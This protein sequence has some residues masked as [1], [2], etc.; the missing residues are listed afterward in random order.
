VRFGAKAR[1]PENDGRAPRVGAVLP[2]DFETE[3]PFVNMTK[4]MLPPIPIDSI[5]QPK[6][7]SDVSRRLVFERMLLPASPGLRTGFMFDLATTIATLDAS[8][9]TE[10]SRD[11]WKSSTSLL[12]ARHPGEEEEEFDEEFDDDEDDDDEADDEFEEEDDIDDEFDDD[13][14]EADDEIDEEIDDIEIE[15]D[16]DFDD[17]DDDDFDDLDDEEEED[18]ID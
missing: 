2:G 18:D 7:R 6:E 3:H 17:D 4:T 1:R 13:D 11:A 15:E 9:D 14:D 5:D 10:E 8:T 12:D 16:D